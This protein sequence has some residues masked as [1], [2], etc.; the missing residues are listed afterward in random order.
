MLVADLDLDQRGDWLELF[1]F[2]T[3][4]RPDAYALAD[5]ARDALTAPR[6]RSTCCGE[7]VELD[8]RDVVDVGCGDGALVRRLA[9]LGARVTGVEV[10]RPTSSRAASAREPVAGE[11]YVHGHRAG[12]RAARRQR[13]R[14]RVHAEPAPRA[15]RRDGRRAGA[16]RRASCA[17]AAPSTCRSRCPRGRSSSSSSSSTTRRRSAPWPRRRWRGRQRPDCTRERELRFDVPVALNEL[18][19]AARPDRRRGSRRVRAA[20]PSSKRALRERYRGARRARRQAD[21]TVPSVAALLSAPLNGAISPSQGAGGASD[22]RGGPCAVH[23]RTCRPPAHA[24]DVLPTSPPCLARY[25]RRLV[26][27]ALC[28]GVLAGPVA[29]AQAA[30]LPPVLDEYASPTSGHDRRRD[31]SLI[32]TV[33]NPN[34][35]ATR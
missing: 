18:R 27:A 13:R 5:R 19:R 7:L 26:L 25:A 33:T 16:R 6:R 8:G 21:V 34:D 30:P 4:R 15:R 3:T 29:A 35:P 14:R 28:L 12:A 10:R 9:G 32:F 11:R 1:P 22:Y 24:H 2:L 20:S 17:P 23:G 31:S